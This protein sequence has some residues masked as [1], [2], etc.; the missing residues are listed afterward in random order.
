[1]SDTD[2]Y[3]RNLVV[4]P[5]RK[6]VQIN[7]ETEE[8]FEESKE[9]VKE[10]VH[11][12]ARTN[13]AFVTWMGIFVWRL[14]KHGVLSVR[15]KFSRSKTHEARKSSHVAPSKKTTPKKPRAKPGQT[16]RPR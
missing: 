16:G 11:Q 7:P 14:I 15:A 9:L 13:L 3:T 12:A 5:K 6:P 8:D 1:M 4:K 2:K 10:S